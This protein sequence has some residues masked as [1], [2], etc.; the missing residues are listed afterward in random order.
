MFLGNK[1]LAENTLVGISVNSSLWSTAKYVAKDN[2]AL[3]S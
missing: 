2:L 1:S 3:K